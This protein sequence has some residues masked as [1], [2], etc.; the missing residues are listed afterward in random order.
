LA[1]PER[2]EWQR[3]HWPASRRQ[4]RLV[5]RVPATAAWFVQRLA[6]AQQAWLG[7]RVEA[8]VACAVAG[9]DRMGG[10]AAYPRSQVPR[11]ERLRQ[12]ASSLCLPTDVAHPRIYARSEVE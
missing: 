9:Q 6:A 1:H 11:P 4:I 7:A 10:P 12:S 5:L 2:A 8:P 3:G